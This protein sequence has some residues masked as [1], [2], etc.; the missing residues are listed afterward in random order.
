MEARRART[1]SAVV[2]RAG[3]WLEPCPS[4]GAEQQQELLPQAVSS[5]AKTA[6]LVEYILASFDTASSMQVHTMVCGN[7]YISSSA[8]H[9]E[10]R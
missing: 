5:R 4:L 2:A 8:A 6:A 3:A 1:G 7:K 9:V 10:A